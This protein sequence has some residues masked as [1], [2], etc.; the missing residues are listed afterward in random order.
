MLQIQEPEIKVPP[1][2]TLC[3]FGFPKA[4]M[5][6]FNCR[7]VTL[8]SL[9]LFL[10]TKWSARIRFSEACCEQG[11]CN[12]PKELQNGARTQVI[13]LQVERFQSNI[14][15]TIITCNLEDIIWNHYYLYSVCHYVINWDCFPEVTVVDVDITSWRLADWE[16]R[17]TKTFPLISISSLGSQYAGEKVH[18]VCVCVSENVCGGVGVP[19][20]HIW[21]C[22]FS[23]R[24]L[25]CCGQME[26]ESAQ[27]PW[28]QTHQK[29][30]ERGKVGG[31]GGKEGK[32]EGKR[33]KGME[34]CWFFHLL[35]AERSAGKQLLKKHT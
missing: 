16:P 25:L 2:E 7:C 10:Q 26:L 6:G 32:D 3:V 34:S 35:S 14:I 27:K 20:L 15:V 31:R 1:S 17:P 21:K 33:K 19:N 28:R 22:F 23:P 4:R 30:E 18:C 13:K 24:L 8:C 11:S 5:D 9:F 12:S 29:K